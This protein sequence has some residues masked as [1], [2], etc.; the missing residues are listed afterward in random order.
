M[1]DIRNDTNY[2]KAKKILDEMK[3]PKTQP[4]AG[5]KSIVDGKDSPS[6]FSAAESSDSA[7]IQGD[8]VSTDALPANSTDPEAGMKRSAS[9]VQKLVNTFEN[10]ESG[11][12]FVKTAVPKDGKNVATDSAFSYVADDSKKG[13]SAVDT[14]P[15]T[16]R[17]TAITPVKGLTLTNPAASE[18]PIEEISDE[19]ENAVK[20]IMDKYLDMQSDHWETFTNYIMKKVRIAAGNTNDDQIRLIA[21]EIADKQIQK[22]KAKKEH[23]V[24]IT[25]AIDAANEAIEGHRVKLNKIKSKW[26]R[27]LGDQEEDLT[28]SASYVSEARAT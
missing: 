16:P 14:V 15:A 6:E 8:F 12:P 24:I 28:R 26:I 13:I 25:N 17:T 27:E 1:T 4:A 5:T 19:I 7:G 9:S 22:Y 21:L 10:V 18:G 20:D 3:M 11:D 23:E 2:D